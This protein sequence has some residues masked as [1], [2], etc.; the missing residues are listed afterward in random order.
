MSLHRLSFLPFGGISLSLN[1]QSLRFLPQYSRSSVYFRMV[2]F[3]VCSRQIQTLIQYLSDNGIGILWQC[4]FNVWIRYQGMMRPLQGLSFWIVHTLEIVHEF[5]WTRR[6]D[7]CR[8]LVHS[9]RCKRNPTV[10]CLRKQCNY[11]NGQVVCG[12]SEGN[13]LTRWLLLH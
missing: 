7:D 6:K 1:H 5:H 10:H 2:G 11:R 13:G 3:L 12:S 9:Y 4:H 8:L